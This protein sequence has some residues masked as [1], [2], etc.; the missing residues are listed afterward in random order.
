MRPA[1]TVLTLVVIFGLLV[2]TAY[3]VRVI[4]RRVFRNGGDPRAA[5]G[6]VVLAAAVFTII[7]IAA[8]LLVPHLESV[9]P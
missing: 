2:A 3:V 6:V 9:V 8:L 1:P 7:S 5:A 4:L